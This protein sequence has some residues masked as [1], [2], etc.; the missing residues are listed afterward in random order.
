MRIR[1]GPAAV[2]GDERRREPLLGK[3]GKARREDDPRVGRPALHPAS[4]RALALLHEAER[5]RPTASALSGMHA[6][7]FINGEI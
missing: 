7:Q 2:I 6:Y 4:A 3:S 5:N 1:Y